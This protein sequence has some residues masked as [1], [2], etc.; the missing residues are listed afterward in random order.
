MITK[1][2]EY[3]SMQL[4]LPKIYPVASHTDN[5]GPGTTFVAIAGSKDDGSRY[6]VK[7]LEKGAST[8]VVQ[9]KSQL[10]D[11]LL[12]LISS[13]KA[14]IV[15]VENCRKSL[16]Q[17]IAQALDYPAKK[18]KL[19][20]ITGTKGKTSTSY[21]TYQL[22]TALGRKVALISTAEK[23]I[24]GNAVSLD[25]T[26][27]LPEHLHIFLDLCVKQDVEYVVMEVSAQSLSLHRVD[28]LEF[29][30]GAF[31]N[32]SL[33]HLEFYPTMD[34]YL[35]AKL[36][37]LDR[38][39]DSK[40]MFINYDDP[41]GA[42]IAKK[43]AD[44]YSFYSLENNLVNYYAKPLVQANNLQIQV[45]DNTETYLIQAHLVGKFN[46]YNLFAATL[47]VHAL[48]FDFAKIVQATEKLSQIPGRM[49]LYPLKNGAYCCI[50]YAHNPSSYE[51]VLSTLRAMTDQLIVVFGAGG[52][53]DKSKRPMMGAIVERYADIAVV[54]SDNPR[55]E[56][57]AAIA[58]D[59]VLGFSYKKQFEY[60]REL[61]RTKAIELA[62]SKSAQGTIV[63]VL[64]KGRDEYQIVGTLTFPF[65]ERAIIRP[66]MKEDVLYK[67]L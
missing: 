21:I 29:E 14:T 26:T 52:D 23:L 64:G 42:D 58:D 53:R 65:K 11:E 7:A 41:A 54:T 27:P 46:A 17:L 55:S 24:A 43:T 30:A 38:I 35:Q 66:F 16:S 22:L 36:L 10:S 9:E 47:M 44:K 19:I 49:E 31:T 62:Y 4:E 1:Q 20:G 5:V 37:F 6:I 57:A 28:G 56:S 18:L 33:E 51:A 45:Q 60:I 3:N 8:I 12:T 13:Y 39:K 40:N 50:D 61:N 32:F 25:L 59:I 48:G 63:A 34:S 2:K 15:Y 67:T